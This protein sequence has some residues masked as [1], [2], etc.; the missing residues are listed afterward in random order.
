M[1]KTLTDKSLNK[2]FK[3]T[4]LKIAKTPDMAFSGASTAVCIING[5]TILCANVGM[6]KCVLGFR[7]DKGKIK[8]KDLTALHDP[9]DEAERARVLSAGG[10][11]APLTI[12]NSGPIGRDRLWAGNSPFP[13]LATTRCLGVSSLSK[14]GCIP[15]PSIVQHTMSP[16]DVFLIM[17]TSPVW[18]FL[19]SQEA[20]SMIASQPNVGDA[21]DFITTEVVK[22]W[23]DEES[24]M[25][26]I[27]INIVFFQHKKK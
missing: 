14:A 18:E 5:T 17:G 26:D 16:N 22:R 15:Q 3:L 13:G 25:P 1:G 2:I 23:T 7:N 20:V 10:R 19:S 24:A 21:L 6:V 4:S 12:D 9:T 8:H 11:I 27:S